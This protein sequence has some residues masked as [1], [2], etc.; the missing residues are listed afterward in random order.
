M[1]VN[2]LNNSY[3]VQPIQPKRTVNNLSEDNKKQRDEKSKKDKKRDNEF[4]DLLKSKYD[5]R[6]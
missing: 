4:S 1:K 5:F 3:R 2:G 6:V